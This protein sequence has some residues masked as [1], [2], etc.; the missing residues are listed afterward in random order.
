MKMNKIMAGI[1]AVCVMGFG[2]PYVNAVT[3]NNSV[4]TASAV[5]YTDGT[6]GLLTY[7]NYGDYIEIFGCDKSATEVVIPAEI[8]GVP[9]TSIGDKAFS[10]CG[11]TSVKIPD[12]VTSIGDYA[13]LNCS[14]LKLVE[15]ADSVTSIGYGAF[16]DCMNL[17]SV[18]M[19]NNITSIAEGL[20]NSCGRLESINIP[21]GVTSIG[22]GAFYFCGSLKSVEIPDSV[23]SIGEIAFSNCYGLTSVEVPESVKSISN[24]AFYCP[25]LKSITI[26]NPECDIFDGDGT[27]SNGYGAFKGTIY[28]YENSTAQAYAEKYGYN[29]ALIGTEPEKETTTGDLNG[30]NSVSVADAVLLQSYILGKQELTEEQFKNADLTG[31]GYVDSFDMVLLRQKIIENNK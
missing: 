11:F 16:I 9:V 15:I 20:F 7:K 12:G 1:M 25:N 2:V 29:F 14:S 21:D 23:T 24:N 17:Q 13:F 8:D 18:K 6:Y 28:G 3:K 27:I 4:I 5:N 19:P 10:Y 22:R 30:D 31:D 26:F